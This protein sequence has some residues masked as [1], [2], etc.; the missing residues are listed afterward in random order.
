MKEKKKKIKSSLI[1]GFTLVVFLS[2]SSKSEQ[3][4]VEFII[5]NECV[6]KMII[7]SGYKELK[8]NDEEGFGVIYGWKSGQIIQLIKGPLNK[9]PISEEDSVMF[10]C[11]DDVKFVIK[12]IDTCK[13]T[14][15]RH[16]KYKSIKGLTI[17]YLNVSNTDSVKFD[18]YLDNIKVEFIKKD[19]D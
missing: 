9:P 1:L 18:Q 19:F 16:D 8:F 12:G 5:D 14:Y 15:W 6:I 2:M 13:K 4:E 10:E 3:K 17:S 11:E 7:P